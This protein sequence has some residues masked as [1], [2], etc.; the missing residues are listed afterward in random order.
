[1]EP[2]SFGYKDWKKLKHQLLG[3]RFPLIEKAMGELGF[4]DLVH[5]AV[6]ANEEPLHYSAG[7]EDVPSLLVFTTRDLIHRMIKGQ[8]EASLL[9]LK[10]DRAIMDKMQSFSLRPYMLGDL[11]A[12]QNSD[13]HPCP[14]KIN[15]LRLSLPQGDISMAEEILFI[16][17]FDD[18]TQKY[19]M[20]DP[21]EALA[22]L[23][24]R[25]EDEERLGMQTVFYS[26][27]NK[28]LPE[29]KEERETALRAKI[30]ELA[31]YA[32]RIPLKR[33]SASIICVLLN[34]ENAME[35]VAFIR[36]YKTF[37]HYTDIIFV[38]SSLEILTGELESI[39]Y[40]G[41]QIDTIFM[42]IVEWQ[43]KKRRGTSVHQVTPG[44]APALSASWN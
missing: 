8:E 42:P 17:L 21:E 32:P 4:Y 40:D 37:D 14:V 27:T 10:Q 9:G 19:M 20:T 25:P 1:M 39:P 29:E 18:V 13:K 33:G 7:P 35:E 44:G 31:F 11:I 30:E 5:V 23:A 43:K 34:L 28:N 41:E 2:K 24:I 16:P 22:L 26:I 38:T 6:D 3:H 36:S 12:G 15:P